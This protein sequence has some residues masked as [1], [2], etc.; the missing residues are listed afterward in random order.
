M[1][2]TEHPTFGKIASRR[3]QG[4]PELRGRAWRA[5]GE[6]KHEAHEGRREKEG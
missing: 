2:G 6:V 1:G 5:G 4:L 3:R